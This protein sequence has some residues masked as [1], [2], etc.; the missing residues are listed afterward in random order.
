MPEGAAERGRRIAQERLTKA[1]ETAAP[2]HSGFAGSTNWAAVALKSEVETLSAINQV[3]EKE[4]VLLRKQLA[5][6]QQLLKLARD[7]I[8]LHVTPSSAPQTN[9]RTM[10]DGIVSSSA[11]NSG[12][13]IESF[14]NAAPTVLH[15]VFSHLERVLGTKDIRQVPRAV[16]RLAAAEARYF[17]VVKT[18]C[19]R[20]RVNIDQVSHSQLLKHLASG[21]P[22]A[23][24]V[25]GEISKKSGVAWT[26]T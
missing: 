22:L 1:R 26:F 17:E 19:V 4:L 5:E 13:L 16:D 11:P 21:D 7:Q 23:S 14:S 3:K 25:S 2:D 24:S 9:L 12:R 10:Q 6:S 20:E 18:V 15:S 8:G